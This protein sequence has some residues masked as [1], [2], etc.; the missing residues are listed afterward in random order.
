MTGA[1][2]NTVTKLLTDIGSVASFYE[3]EHLRGL[4]SRRIECD[5]IWSFCYAKKGN[6]PEE[7]RGEFGY[8]DVW[9]WVALDADSKLAITWLLGERAG[10]DARAFMGDLSERLKQRVQIATDGH[11][12]YLDAVEIAFG[13]NVDY[14]QVYE[15]Y[16]KD[17]TEPESRYSPAKC[18]SAESPAIMGDPKRA[19]IST[20]LR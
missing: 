12:A 4:Y 15:E 7:H 6:V 5:E 20:Q 3:D 16:G 8:G 17:P 11:K 10:A 14:A 13:A 18:L 1:A 19:Y 9:T 2:K